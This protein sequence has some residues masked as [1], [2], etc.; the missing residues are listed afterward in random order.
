MGGSHFALVHDLKGGHVP[1]VDPAIARRTFA[2]LHTAI[3]RGL[4]RACHDLSEGG[5]AAAM[6]EMAFAGGFGA[7]IELAKMPHAITLTPSVSHDPMAAI[8]LF[9]ESNT[10]FLCEVPDTAAEAF[11]RALSGLPHACLGRVIDSPTL[12]IARDGH[13]LMMVDLELQSAACQT[14]VN[15]A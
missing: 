7:A 5:L 10:R 15:W 8:L 11:E 6:A 9:S 2:A 4:V 14:L 12:E 3:D 1:Q 13:P